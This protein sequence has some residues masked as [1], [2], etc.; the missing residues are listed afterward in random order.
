MGGTVVTWCWW[1]IWPEHNQGVKSRGCKCNGNFLLIYIYH[2]WHML[3]NYLDADKTPWYLVCRYTC[4]WCT[5][6]RL[7]YWSIQFQSNRY[8]C[9]FVLQMK[10]LLNCFMEHECKV[11]AYNILTDWHKYTLQCQ[12]I[13]LYHSMT[14]NSIFTI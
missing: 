12:C 9:F 10:I 14:I 4:I 11:H 8:Q 5:V 3:S 1:W 7:I 6:T 2:I 13:D